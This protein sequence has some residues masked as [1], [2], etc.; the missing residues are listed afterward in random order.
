MKS[1]VILVCAIVLS[2]NNRLDAQ[3]NE[4]AITNANNFNFNQFFR[5][6]NEN[7]KPFLKTIDGTYF[8]LAFLNLDSNGHI[9]KVEIVMNPSKP[10][11]D[12]LAQYTKK[13]LYAASGMYHLTDS[14]LHSGIIKNEVSIAVFFDNSEDTDLF[15]NSGF[16]AFDSQIRIVSPGFQKYILNPRPIHV[17]LR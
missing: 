11:P 13:M 15:S 10:L 4:L 9:S 8:C 3:G 14:R 16:I 17:A 5:E 7:N 6:F 2:L 1:K 12:I